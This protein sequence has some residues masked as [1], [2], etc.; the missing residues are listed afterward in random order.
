MITLGNLAAWIIRAALICWWFSALEIVALLTPSEQGLIHNSI[1]RYFIF[2]IASLLI[3]IIASG[4]PKIIANKGI[5]NLKKVDCFYSHSLSTL[6]FLLQGSRNQKI[7]RNIVVL[8]GLKKVYLSQNEDHLLIESA[9]PIRK[10]EYIESIFIIV[11]GIVLLFIAPVS[12]IILNSYIAKILV[13]LGISKNFAWHIIFDS[14]ATLLVYY[15]SPYILRPLEYKNSSAVIFSKRIGGDFSNLVYESPIMP[16]L[17]NCPL[18]MYHK[19]KI[20]ISPLISKNQRIMSYV[21][22]HEE[23][24]ILDHYNNM[25]RNILSPI[26]FP[27]LLY[28]VVVIVDYLHFIG[29]LHYTFWSMFFIAAV[30]ISLILLTFI[31]IELECQNRADNYAIKKIGIESLIKALQEIAYGT[32]MLPDKYKSQAIKLIERLKGK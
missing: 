8:S 5:T 28:I 7:E 25:M 1:L 3:N 32:N 9:K 26:L 19:G 13:I 2:I 6:N 20:I 18:G 23:G 29:I 10:I 14:G 4:L 22:G 11:I 24:H 27:W 15:L 12:L 16:F 30:I 21:I 31:R 17:S